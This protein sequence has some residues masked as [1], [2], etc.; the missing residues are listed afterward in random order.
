MPFYRD[1]PNFASF[2]FLIS[3]NLPPYLPSLAPIGDT[4]QVQHW[5]EFWKSHAAFIMVSAHVEQGQVILLFKAE[6]QYPFYF[7]RHWSAPA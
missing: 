6:K 5:E 4:A 7:S 3:G 2:M 1:I